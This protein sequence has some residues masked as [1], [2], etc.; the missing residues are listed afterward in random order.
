MNVNNIGIIESP[1]I[2]LNTCFIKNG[3][4]VNNPTTI[5]LTI[6]LYRMPQLLTSTIGGVPVAWDISANEKTRTKTKTEKK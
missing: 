6:L 5:N 4:N 2:S 3:A 1:N